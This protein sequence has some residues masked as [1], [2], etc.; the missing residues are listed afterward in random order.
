VTGLAYKAYV[1]QHVALIR[2]HDISLAELIH[3]WIKNSFG[4]QQFLARYIY[5]DKPGLNLNQVASIPIP[6]PPETTRAQVF[7]ALSRLN[8][9]CGQ[10]A[11][12]V[13]S[14]RHLCRPLCNNGDHQHNR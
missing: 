2:L 12:Q 14:E 9:M 13:N 5:G 3:F 10:L 1:S 11:Q 6:L 8:A 4:G 7:A